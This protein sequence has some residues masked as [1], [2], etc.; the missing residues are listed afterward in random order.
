MTAVGSREIWAHLD[1]LTKPARSLGRLEDLAARLCEIQQT[2]SP[3]TMPRRLV[4]FAADHGVA[5]AGVTAWPS[6]VTRLM[7]ANIREGGA[8]SSVLARQTQTELVLIDVGVLGAEILDDRLKGSAGAAIRFRSRRIRPGTRDLSE[9]PALSVDEFEQGLRVG[10][11][12]ARAAVA[13]GV[14]V[15]ATGEMGIGNTTP[16]ACLALL[17]ADVPL[18]EAVGRGAGADDKT[19]A[20]KRAVVARATSR[21]R[22]QR[23]DDPLAGVAA[24]AG[25]EIAAMAGFFVEAHAAG[26]TVLLDGYVASAAALVAEMI[27]P[28]TSRSMIA[29]HLSA[30]PGHRRV[31]DRLGLEPF[32]H[33]QMRL[34]EGTGALLLLP[35]VD[36]AAA[37]T[38]QMARLEDR[39]INR[40]A[41]T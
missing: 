30:E 21:V 3:Q 1:S 33:W 32:L 38:N 35:L 17:L 4:L 13:D 23:A 31:L 24:V 26:L 14:R 18:E 11:E 8:A 27:A 9:Q 16:A 22:G 36:A 29:A 2:L 39:G 20:R 37:L 12:E 41:G 7:I 40:K 34:G 19:L 25:L 6:E 28:G 15:V 5:A 10:R